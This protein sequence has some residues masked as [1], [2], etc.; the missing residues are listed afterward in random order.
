VPVAFAYFTTLHTLFL[1]KREYK[2][3]LT[4]RLT[5]M[6]VGDPDVNVQKVRG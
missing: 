4:L 6:S 3:F 5:Y 2:R 1:L